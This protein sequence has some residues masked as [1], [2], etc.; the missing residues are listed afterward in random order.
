MRQRSS[1]YYTKDIKEKHR[2]HTRGFRRHERE[3]QKPIKG[4][5][6]ISERHIVHQEHKKWEIR[7]KRETQRTSE[8]DTKDIRGQ[9]IGY[10]S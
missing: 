2:Q 8:K 10:Q 7:Q 1:K 4:P 6:N 5:Q 9:P 3:I